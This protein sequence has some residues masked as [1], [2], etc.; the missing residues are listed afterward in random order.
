MLQEQLKKAE[1][2]TAQAQ[3]E[4]VA[5][6]NTLAET[7]DELVKQ[8]KLKCKLAQAVNA[9]PKPQAHA[10]FDGAMALTDTLHI[11]GGGQ[12]EAVVTDTAKWK[13]STAIAYAFC[14]D[15]GWGVS[16]DS[17]H[18]A[19]P[20]YQ[21]HMKASHKGKGKKKPEYAGTGKS[22]SGYSPLF[23]KSWAL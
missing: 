10:V 11:I 9:L 14:T 8:M 17:L 23:P 13:G 21:A 7:K 6:L 2:K 1:N 22:W 12:L 18:D 15:C 3:T 4:K 19:E 20:A 16:A 5:V